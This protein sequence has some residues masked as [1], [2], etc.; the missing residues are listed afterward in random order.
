MSASEKMAYEVAVIG[1]AAVGMNRLTPSPA[2]RRWASS[3]IT[4]AMASKE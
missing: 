3:G 1:M 4:C 2:P